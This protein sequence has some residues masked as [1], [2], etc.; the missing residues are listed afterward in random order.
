MRPYLEAQSKQIYVRCTQGSYSFPAHYHNHTEVVFCFSGRQGVKL[1][2]RMYEMIGGDAL[3]I[4][5]NTSH[6]HIELDSDE[7]TKSLTMICNTRLFG[8]IIPDIISKNSEDSLIPASEI[9]DNIR[10]AFNEMLLTDDGAQKFGWA[11]I[12]LSGLLKSLDLKRTDSNGELTSRMISYIDQ[13]F[14][15]PLTINYLAKE[16]GYNPSYIANLFCDKL[17]IPFRT[18]LGSVRAEY[19]A[20]QIRT[21]QKSLTEIA[22]DSGCNSLNTFCRCFKKHFGQTP[23]QYKKNLNTKNKEVTR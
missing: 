9:S 19:A 4:F 5:P 13:N 11:C 14:Q 10:L 22:Y 6:E 7:N 2:D 18:Y 12:A 16:F 8:E 23:S 17:K 15:E 3:I 1:G 20:S 21:T